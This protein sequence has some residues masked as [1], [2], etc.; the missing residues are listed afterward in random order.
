MVAIGLDLMTLLPT[1]FSPNAAFISD[2]T[3]GVGDVKLLYCCIVRLDWADWT[4]SICD[5]Y[6]L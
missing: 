3:A 6:L 1:F 2:F 4:A 5:L